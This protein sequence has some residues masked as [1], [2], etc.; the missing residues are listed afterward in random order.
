MTMIGWDSLSQTVLMARPCQHLER[1]SGY[2]DGE[3]GSQ[4]SSRPRLS[5]WVAVGGSGLI[6][7]A[8]PLEYTLRPR[9]PPL[10]RLQRS[11]SSGSSSSETELSSLP[12]E[13]PAARVR[14]LKAE[15]AEVEAEMTRRQSGEGSDAGPSGT[16]TGGV[17][18]SR[19]SV[20][21]P[22]P[23]V[24]LL[25]ELRDLRARM[26][27]FQVTDT[28]PSAS[29]VTDVRVEW[30]ERLHR[31]AGPSHS[32]D[33][34]GSR[35]NAEQGSE[36][37]EGNGES[38]RGRA[39]PKLSE[40][41]KRLATLEDLVGPFGAADEVGYALSYNRSVADDFQTPSAPLLATLARQD[42]LLTLLT[43]P[44]QLDAISRK[45]KLL[46]V[47]LDRAA[48][49]SR[50]AGQPSGASDRPAPTVTLSAEEHASLQS[51]FAILP[52]LDPLVPIL[53]PLLARLRSLAGLHAEAA[54][55]ADSL[56]KLQSE[57]KRSTEEIT[58]LQA[59]VKA[60][61]EGLAD[62]AQSVERNWQGLDARMKSLDERIRKLDQ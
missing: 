21:P 14:R 54:E 28:S 11:S 48:A 31:L 12:R 32:A 56:R 19:K 44:R 8:D 58:E 2:L 37:Q 59:L 16:S 34:E 26:E 41:D 18:P 47:D 7:P 39:A 3:H 60:V 4:V 33:Q 13:T 42:H 49:A 25:A 29:N 55:V 30:S 52:R 15:L 61:Q 38:S 23:P 53:D 24:D 57:D 62:S 1:L 43:Q 45:V 35:R 46:L 22:K 9:L 36:R 17:V 20:L 40:L 10:R 50:R 5:L 6:Y 27:G 51:L